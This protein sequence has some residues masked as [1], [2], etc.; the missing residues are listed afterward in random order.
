[1]IELFFAGSSYTAHTHPGNLE[2]LELS[3]NFQ[4]P[5]RVREFDYSSRNF[6][7]NQEFFV[8]KLIFCLRSDI[9]PSES[10]PPQF[11]S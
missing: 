8:S 4:K 2:N 10:G 5:T 3:G 11:Q 1:M 7:L 6:D 9:L